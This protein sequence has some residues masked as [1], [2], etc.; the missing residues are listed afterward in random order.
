[1]RS[2][3]SKKLIEACRNKLLELRQKHVESLRELSGELVHESSGDIAD[4]AR[5]LQEE[6]MSLARREKISAELQE[7]NLA[8]DRIKNE[9]FGIC[10]ETGAPIEEKRLMAIPW[11]RL[12][13][14][15]AEMREMERKEEEEFG[16]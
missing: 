15:G 16:S 5:A 2:G 9:T 12:S 10:E 1:M 7:I 4:Q 14:E 11:T 8:L 6:A 3:I 13:L